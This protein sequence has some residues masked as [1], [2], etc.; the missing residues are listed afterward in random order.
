MRDRGLV[1]TYGIGKLLLAHVLTAAQDGD[2]VVDGTLESTSLGLAFHI[3]TV[4]RRSTVVNIEL[5][6]DLPPAMQPFERMGDSRHKKSPPLDEEAEDVTES[7]RRD[8]L[9]ALDLNEQ[10]NKLRGLRK[11]DAGYLI[12]NRSELAK[13]V[14]T[15]KTMINKIIRPARET[16]KV[17]LVD[18][19]VYVGRIRTALQLPQVS[20]VTVKAS[21]ADVVR[22]IADLPDDAFLI[23]EKEVERLSKRR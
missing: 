14:G 2:S 13:A 15:D 19:S 16:S 17:D 7:F 18:R 9:K 5:P 20:K 6:T 3:R 11:D 21:R 23:F 12:S 4:D 8:V 22:F 1:D 10:H